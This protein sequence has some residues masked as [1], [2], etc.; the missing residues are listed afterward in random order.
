ML[1]P[2]LR[3][4]AWLMLVGVLAA[5]A[6]NVRGAAVALTAPEVSLR[7]MVAV[8]P[9]RD[10]AQAEHVVVAGTC[11]SLGRERVWVRVTS[12]DG[13]TATAEVAAD[14]RTG[15]FSVEYP[16]GFRGA[17]PL[18]AGVYFIDAALTSG[19]PALSRAEVAVVVF[20]SRRGRLPDLPSAFT[21]DLR[22]RGGEQDAQSPEWPRV[23]A[24]ANLYY[25]SR[26]AALAGVEREF[27]LARP[28]DLKS[29][30]RSLSLY[31]FE[32][33]DRD[34]SQPLGRRVARGFW[35]AV[36]DTWFGPSNDDERPVGSG[37]YPAYTFTNDTADILV[38]YL[39][40]WRLQ[41]RVEGG[42]EDN[43][44]ELCRDVLANLRALQR[45][46][47]ETGP[48]QPGVEG[49]G[50]FYYGLF[51]DGELMLDGTGWFHA[52]GR[53]DHR[54]GGVFLGRATWAL[55]EA[56]AIRPEGLEEAA[57]RETLRRA[58]RWAF[59]GA[60]AHADGGRPYVRWVTSTSGPKATR[61]LWRSPG[62]H[63]Y[64]L[65][66][67]VAACARP[68]LAGLRIFE[69]GEY[70][71]SQAE[72]LSSLTQQGLEA[73][74]DVVQPS[75]LFST[76]ADVDAVAVTA[77]V[78]GARA[79][80]AHPSAE[81]WRACARKVTDGW[82]AARPAAADYRGPVVLMA[83]RRDPAQPEELRYRAH[84]S[85][86]THLTYFHTGLWMQ[87]L[88]EL[89]ESEKDPRYAR[90]FD[91]LFG[92]F[93]GNNPFDARLF[94]EVGG[95]YN[96]VTDTDGDTVEDRLRF[97]LYPESTAFVQIAVLRALEIRA[98]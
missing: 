68:E 66:G 56:L 78:R 4:A 25:G 92:Y 7:A 53:V 49:A 1:L 32:G 31:D 50:A 73:L 72:T 43:T 3:R 76:F 8:S 13:Q 95:V 42:M 69:A 29:F 18:R 96:F 5:S 11:A 71:F 16:A 33:R 6:G 55:G 45:R 64:L 93:C 47:D 77:L 9:F 70:G 26:G 81:R 79:F 51:A 22:G 85:A 89:E 80:Q 91:E 90:R 19:A 75:G 52:P 15:R 46:A 63:A 2:W 98:R 34:W 74:A 59:G 39:R 21:T 20:D 36:W 94:T 87:A 35:Q 97:D 60:Q 17:A 83:G 44:A 38:A 10:L 88:A 62:E 14:T 30:K 58:L 27:D 54:R 84:R 24:L 37:H 41:D 57:V 61:L 48:T 40:R 67:M 86:S 23:R 65:Q 82:M 28:E 12:G